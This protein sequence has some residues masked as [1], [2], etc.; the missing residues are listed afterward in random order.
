MALAPI[1]ASAFAGVFQ[2]L[3][4]LLPSNGTV[5]S[6]SASGAIFTSLCFST[7]FFTISSG[8]C[9]KCVLGLITEPSWNT[10]AR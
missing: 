7:I 10:S 3:G 9:S 1:C 2:M 4:L 8:T 6:V 5:A